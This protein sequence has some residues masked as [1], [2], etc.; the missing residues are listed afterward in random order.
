M[1]VDLEQS[2]RDFIRQRSSVRERTVAKDVMDHLIMQN[3]LTV[4]LSDD[5]ASAAALRTVQRFVKSCGF[6]R[7]K[8][9]G[10]TYRMSAENESKRDH[11]VQLMTSV[12][13]DTF[14]NVYLDESYIHHN[15]ASHNDSLYDPT[16]PNMTKAKHK[17]HRFCFIPAII[18]KNRVL[19][20]AE[21]ST[22]DVAHLLRDTI[23][24]FEG[25][26]R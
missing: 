16:D 12:D 19:P 3:A 23:N 15:Y 18:D 24:I 21:H 8:R 25:G 10:S 20:D 13:A 1:T 11:Y 2:V 26:K 7:G 22:A 6:K 9:K 4:D 5:A 17:G 14:R